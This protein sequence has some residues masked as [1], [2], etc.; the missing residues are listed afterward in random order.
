[1]R[2]LASAFLAECALITWRNLH[3]DKALPPPSQFTGA[4]IIYG[5]LALLPQSGAG[6]A[7]VMGWS[8]VLATFLNLWNPAAPLNLTKSAS[9]SSTASSGPGTM[10]Q[11]AGSGKVPL[12]P[13]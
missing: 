11:A 8:V 12:Q 6:F 2:G 3:N 4:C 1:V 13:A 10:G 5:S 7:S 9:T